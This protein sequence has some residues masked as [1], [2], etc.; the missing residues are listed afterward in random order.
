MMETVNTLYKIKEAD[1]GMQSN[2]TWRHAL[3]TLLMVLA[4]FAPHITE[5]LWHQL[6][7][8]DT[9]HIDHWP[10]WDD[11]ILAAESHDI[12]IQIN[13]KMRAQVT[14]P[15]TA[16]QADI[17]A[18]AL[19]NPRVQQYVADK[20]PRRIIYVPGRLINIVV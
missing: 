15:R 11:A 1:G 14:V 3:E 6:G 10:T 9:I 13:G 19:A 4:P 7:H 8:T 12:H 17:E 5:E 16:T 2:A 18:A 20:E